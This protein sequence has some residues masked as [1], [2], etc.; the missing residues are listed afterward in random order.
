MEGTKECK[1]RG[2]E[3]EEVLNT[4]GIKYRQAMARGR[5]ELGKVFLEGKS[6][7]GLHRLGRKRRMIV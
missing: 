7:N 3:V 2:D 4:V 6:H 1:R 5:R